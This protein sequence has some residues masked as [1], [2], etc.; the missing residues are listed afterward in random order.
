MKTIISRSFVFSLLL[1]V[2]LSSCNGSQPDEGET[3]TDKAQTVRLVYTE[4]SE[5]IAI[6]YLAKALLEEELGYKV[7][8][9]LTD[10]ESAYAEVANQK[11][12]FFSDAWLPETQIKYFEQHQDKLDQVGIIYPEARTGLLV[13]DYSSLQ[14]IEDLI[15]KKLSIAGIDS[16][17]GIMQQANNAIAS[18]GLNVE[19]L[20]ESESQMT[21]KLDHAIKRREE[22]VVTGWE[23]HW[24]FARY[25]LRFL[26]DPKEVFGK[27]EKIYTIGHKELGENLP[28]A[29]RFFERMQLSEKQ[30]NQLIDYVR[31]EDD[32][33][34]G[35]KKWIQKNE[36][37]VNQWVKD[38]HPT[39]KKIM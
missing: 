15:G 22:I 23:P 25:D 20:A 35:V 10:V 11:A 21:Q 16:T 7:E 27:K 14:S 8:M 39:R 19:L 17:A 26:E 30:L 5:A 29:Q 12:D 24:I 9:K 36:F 38:L 28:R 3:A 33:P 31:V 37:I 34:I 2:V 4:W 32:P 6:T 1:A 13:P 18:Y